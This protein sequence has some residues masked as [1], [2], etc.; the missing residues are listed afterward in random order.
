MADCVNSG[1]IPSPNPIRDL[2]ASSCG[3]PG[4]RARALSGWAH[5]RLRTGPGSSRTGRARFLQTTQMGMEPGHY[6]RRPCADAAKIQ[7]GAASALC[8]VRRGRACCKHYLRSYSPPDDA[9][10]K[11][12]LYGP[13]A[14]LRCLFVRGRCRES[15]SVSALWSQFRR[16]ETSPAA[17]K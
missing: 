7:V 8:G 17:V 9:S 5:G 3:N 2:S 1:R 15:H 11:R 16:N 6:C 12:A 10:T 13:C 4:S 14:D